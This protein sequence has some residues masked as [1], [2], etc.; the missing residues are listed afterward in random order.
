VLGAELLGK[1][2]LEATDEG[3]GPG[4]SA[5]FEGFEEILALVAE[6]IGARN[7]QTVLW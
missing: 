5:R 6:K 3:A 4:E 2:G 1:G 7:G